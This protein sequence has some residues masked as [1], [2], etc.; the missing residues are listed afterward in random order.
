[1]EAVSII[2][3]ALATFGPIITYA[4]YTARFGEPRRADKPRKKTGI[5]SADTP[6]GA[7]A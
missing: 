3:F 4:I 7:S 2:I 6:G 5:A 1:M